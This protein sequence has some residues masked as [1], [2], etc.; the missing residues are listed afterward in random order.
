MSNAETLHGKI[1][2]HLTQLYKHVCTAVIDD[3]D[4]TAQRIAHVC[5]GTGLQRHNQFACGIIVH[6]LFLLRMYCSVDVMHK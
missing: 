6:G 2:I 1:G 5:L 3:L 4:P